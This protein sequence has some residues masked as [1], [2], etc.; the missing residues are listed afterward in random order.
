MCLIIRRAKP[1]KK[2]T[3]F[4]LPKYISRN[5]K[6]NILKNNILNPTIIQYIYKANFLN[7]AI[8]YTI[9]FLFL[10]DLLFLSG[11]PNNGKDNVTS[12]YIRI[13]RRRS[14]L[15]CTKHHSELHFS[16]R[17]IHHSRHRQPNRLQ[18]HDNSQVCLR[19]LCG[20]YYGIGR[21]FEDQ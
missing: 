13:P 12:F 10:F 15:F 16:E 17:A 5:I 9:C 20:G 19:T 4:Y 1:F 11:T 2:D 3:F 7:R 14:G 6:H 8:I 21:L 18:R